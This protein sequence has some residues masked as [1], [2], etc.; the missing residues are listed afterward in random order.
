MNKIEGFAVTTPKTALVSDRRYPKVL[1]GMIERARERVWASLFMVDLD[2]ATD[3]KHAVLGILD[4]LAATRWRGADVRLI[5]SG[6]RDN[7]IIAEATATAVAVSR[8]MGIPTKWLG[9]RARRGSH[10]KFVIADNEV[11]LG[12]HNW[13]PTAFLTSKQD[14]AWFESP[15]L[16]AYLCSLFAAQWL[17]PPQKGVK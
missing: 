15:S 3:R 9:A 7:L 16:A 17:R 2:V 4:E 5:V 10:A 14:S 8:Q 12:S 6:S 1:S 11:L 13:S